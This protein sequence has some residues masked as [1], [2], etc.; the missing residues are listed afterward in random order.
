[1]INHY[2]I[3]QLKILDLVFVYDNTDYFDFFGTRKYESMMYVDYSY[4]ENK[5]VFPDVRRTIQDEI[6]EM[7]GLHI[8]L[9][10]SIKSENFLWKLLISINSN[11]KKYM[12]R[13]KIY[14]YQ[15][16][17]KI[18]YFSKKSK[19]YPEEKTLFKKDIKTEKVFI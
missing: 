9:D 15:I 12:V 18:F 8:D 6:Y 11:Q 1:M 5:I 14:L 10:I 16:C 13:V 2:L 17:L 3:T 4:D 19:L 7:I